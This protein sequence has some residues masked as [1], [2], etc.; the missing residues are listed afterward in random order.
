MSF[1]TKHA[2]KLSS[3]LVLG[4]LSFACGD[5]GA[6]AEPVKE[7]ESASTPGTELFQYTGTLVSIL[8]TDESMRI[9]VPHLIE[10]RNN[11]TGAPLDPP[12]STMSAL[13]AT[14]IGV[15]AARRSRF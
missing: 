12:I 6:G 9:G 15:T 14:P 3:A 13:K 10:L 2:Y 7:S 8:A 1:Q 5:D 4:A 11:E